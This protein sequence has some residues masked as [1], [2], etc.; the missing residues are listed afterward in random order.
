[1]KRTERLWITGTA[2]VASLGSATPSHAQTT[3]DAVGLVFCGCWG[4]VALLGL[5]FLAFWVWMLIDSIQREEYEY[6]NSTGNSKT[7]WLVVL[8][9]SWLV[10]F[11][12]LAAILYYFMIYKKVRRGTVGRP[13][14]GTPGGTP[15]GPGPQ[16]RTAPPPPPGGSA[17]PPP[18]PEPPSGPSET[19]PPP[20]PTGEER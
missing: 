15:P 14:G 6:P 2:L 19:P 17:P 20:P 10:G 7:V 1:M 3:D 8:L 11:Y 13:A 5:A 4:I 18:P 12:W 16:T 9:A